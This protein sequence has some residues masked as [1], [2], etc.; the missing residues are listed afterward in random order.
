MFTL[1]ENEAGGAGMPLLL[2]KKDFGR[3]REGQEEEEE[4]DV[5][6]RQREEE[7]KPGRSTTRSADCG[8][9]HEARGAG[10]PV[11]LPPPPFN[12]LFPNVIV[13][14]YPS[15]LPSFS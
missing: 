9:R 13:L 6:G 1:A 3:R 7:E 8:T 15:L 5:S 14:S 12:F 11:L 2:H 4:D 10:T